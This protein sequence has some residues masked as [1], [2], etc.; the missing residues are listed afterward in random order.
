MPQVEIDKKLAW[1]LQE[2]KVVAEIAWLG[3]DAGTLE[4]VMDAAS[5]LSDGYV[6]GL[7]VAHHLLSRWLRLPRQLG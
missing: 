6:E 3:R 5:L 7:R 4:V 1:Y 2:E